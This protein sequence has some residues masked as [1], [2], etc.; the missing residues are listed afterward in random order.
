V[1]AGTWC[2]KKKDKQQE[3]VR[4]RLHK[5]SKP[6]LLK[7]DS[8]KRKAASR[9]A[10]TLGSSRAAKRGAANKESSESFEESAASPEA[11]GED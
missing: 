9:G 5:P 4:K 1:G 3:D 11:S 2:H 8:Q 10:T 6:V 7:K